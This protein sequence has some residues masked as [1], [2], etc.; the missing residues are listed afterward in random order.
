MSFDNVYAVK[1]MKSAQRVYYIN[2]KCVVFS[3]DLRNNK[4]SILKPITANGS[5]KVRIQHT[6]HLISRLMIKAFK[7]KLWEL[8]KDNPKLVVAHKDK[9]I[10]NNF[11]DNLEVIEKGQNRPSHTRK[12]VFINLKTKKVE[13]FNSIREAERNTKMHFKTIQRALDG[14]NY[15]ESDNLKIIE[16]DQYIEL[17]NK[18][19]RNNKNVRKR[20]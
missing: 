7:P 16:Y 13:F 18:N 8:I 3:K 9:D 1:I 6:D 5:V 19:K 2:E 14:L 15:K 12:V 4:Y 10:H 11:L 20:R 17:C